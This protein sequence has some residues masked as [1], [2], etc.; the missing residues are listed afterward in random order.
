M[1]VKRVTV[2]CIYSTERMGDVAAKT[3]PKVLKAQ[4]SDMLAF[5]A[6]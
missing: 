4:L 6:S 1:N 2:K 3:V 5:L